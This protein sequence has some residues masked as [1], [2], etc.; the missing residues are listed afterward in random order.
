MRSCAGCMLQAGGLCDA[1]VGSRGLSVVIRRAC[2]GGN[3]QASGHQLLTPA[4]RVP[5]LKVLNTFKVTCDGTV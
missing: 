5:D 3:K 4:W 2:S 1:V